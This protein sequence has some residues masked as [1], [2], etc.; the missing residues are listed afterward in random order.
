M[1]LLQCCVNG[2]RT[3]ADHPAVPLTPAEIAEDCRLAVR[4]GAQELH[5]HPRDGDG[6][7]TLDPWY[8][9]AT[10]SAVH[11][12][13]PGIPLGLTTIADAQPDPIRRL[14]LVRAWHVPPDYVSV[15][16][17]E[18][19]AL[20]LCAALR[21][22]KI[23]IEAGLWGEPDAER[24]IASGLADR[25]LRV[26]IE[27]VDVD[28]AT[29]L[30]TARSMSRLVRGARIALPQLV[31]GRDGAAW[32]VL[33]AALHDGDDVRIGLEDTLVRDDGATARDNAELVAIAGRTV[34]RRHEDETDTGG[35]APA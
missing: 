33:V 22:R 24:L 17:S 27:P 3:R 35:S 20:E 16:F 5:V 8:C 9:D 13:C 23:G 6:R 29:A 7:Q 12:T 10:V 4:A 2:R 14:A 26:L 19:G 28:P 11:A 25:C 21:E 15:N 30:R 32:H 34:E 1:T 31:H 18:D